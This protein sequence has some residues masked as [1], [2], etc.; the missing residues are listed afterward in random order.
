MSVI[1]A[2]AG[3]KHWSLG[4]AHWDNLEGQDG[5]GGAGWRWLTVY[6]HDAYT[7]ALVQVDEGD[8]DQ[9]KNARMIWKATE[10]VWSLRLMV[11]LAEAM[12]LDDV[13][14]VL[15]GAQSLLRFIDFGEIVNEEIDGDVY[16]QLAAETHG[17]VYSVNGK[18]LNGRG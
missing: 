18:V 10:L 4:E 3:A 15:A 11:Q 7:V 6:D 9:E 2:V 12:G 1:G 16:A 13:T 8:P 17:I 14:P 5:E